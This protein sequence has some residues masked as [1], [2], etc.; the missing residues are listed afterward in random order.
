MGSCIPGALS[1]PAKLAAARHCCRCCSAA[2]AAALT[3]CHSG[4]L[5]SEAVDCVVTALSAGTPADEG[6]LTEAPRG[7]A[8]SALLGAPED[9]DRRRVS[10]IATA[11]AVAW[12]AAG[13]EVRCL[14]VA[15]GSRRARF[16]SGGAA[17]SAPTSGSVLVTAA[18]WRAA[19]ALLA[20]AAAGTSGG[21]PPNRF[22]A[23]RIL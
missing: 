13:D 1:S 11:G 9:V 17:P 19:L 7:S 14:G 21:S 2:S 16:C 12:R 20:A 15:T 10:R 22:F 18:G 23:S 4:A 6:L 8:G 3:P 5:Y